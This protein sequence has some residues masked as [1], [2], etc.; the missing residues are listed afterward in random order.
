MRTRVPLQ[1]WQMGDAYYAI[2][3]DGNPLTSSHTRWAKLA[4]AKLTEIR[5]PAESAV[6]DCIYEDAALVRCNV[7]GYRI[8]TSREFIE[9]EEAS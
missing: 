4:G 9:G 6:T 1:L 5:I 2:F 7:G 3:D 8:M